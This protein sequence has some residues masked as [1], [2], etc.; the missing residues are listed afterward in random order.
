MQVGH[1]FEVYGIGDEGPDL[2]RISQ[3]TQSELTKKNKKIKEVSKKNPNLVGFPVITIGKKLDTLVNNGYNV[4]VIEEVTPPPKPDRKVTGVYSI[5]THI[6]IIDTDDANNI[7]SLYIELVPQ[8]KKDPLL[9]VGISMVDLSTGSVS[10]KE[11]YSIHGDEY[12]A[13]DETVRFINSNRPK[14][15]IIHY[16]IPKKLKTNTK[17]FTQDSL[18]KYLELSASLRP[19]VTPSRCS[20][21]RIKRR[22]PSSYPLRSRSCSLKA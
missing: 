5:G 2:K 22:S 10:F 9:A 19:P 18:I 6:D 1:F 17:A 14:E 4:V 12:Y 13:L 3:I 7:V 15:I 11:T 16:D 8:M 21:R 20:A